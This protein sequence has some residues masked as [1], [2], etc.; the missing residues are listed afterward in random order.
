MHRL[1]DA[2]TDKLNWLRTQEVVG[3]LCP[4]NL[5]LLIQ[6]PSV[7]SACHVIKRPSQK[8]QKLGFASTPILPLDRALDVKLVCDILLVFMQHLA[9]NDSSSHHAGQVPA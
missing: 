7:H 9:C 3:M 6:A 4:L 1:Q 8:Q 2:L 5:K